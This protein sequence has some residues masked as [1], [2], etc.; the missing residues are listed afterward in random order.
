MTVIIHNGDGVPATP[1]PIDADEERW[2]WFSWDRPVLSSE[3]VLPDGLQKLDEKTNV[4]TLG[5]FGKTYKNCNGVL[6]KPTVQNGK[7]LLTNR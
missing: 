4:E 5:D 2:V 6:V 3:W 7:L 1:M